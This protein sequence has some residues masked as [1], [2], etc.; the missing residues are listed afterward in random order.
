VLSVEVSGGCIHRDDELG[1][2][3]QG[4][5]EETV[6]WLVANDAQLGQWIADED[7]LDEL[8]NEVRLVAQDVRGFFKCRWTGP[9]LNKRV[10]ARRSV[11]TSCCRKGTWRA[12]NAGI[13]DDSQGRASRAVALASVV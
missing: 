5:L 10:P 9:C 8:G 11:P 6:I 1:V 4:A 3:R 2:R 13:K 7:E 12:Q